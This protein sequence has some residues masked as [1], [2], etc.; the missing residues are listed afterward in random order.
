MH[1]NCSQQT[2]WTVF[3]QLLAFVASAVGI[4]VLELNFMQLKTHI[5]KH[6]NC[7]YSANYP[8]QSTYTSKSSTS[9][10]SLSSLVKWEKIWGEKKRSSSSKWIKHIRHFI[11]GHGFKS[12]H[13]DKGRIF[14]L[15][16]NS[17]FGNFRIEL[18][19]RLQA[20]LI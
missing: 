3:S 11:G 13:Y 7:T 5:C 6:W 9:H 12:P 10:S 2:L 20:S 14:K 18:E 8:Q 15:N 1:L 19:F 16:W 4:T 17:A